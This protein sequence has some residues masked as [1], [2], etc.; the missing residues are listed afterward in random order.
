MRTPP[1]SHE[2][3]RHERTHPAPCPVHNHPMGTKPTRPG[4][5]GREQTSKGQTG[6][7]K[8]PAL[9]QGLD[10]ETRDAVRASP[11]SVVAV[12]TAVTV[13]AHFA[14]VV[15]AL[16]TGAGVLRNAEHALHAAGNAA[17]HATN[18][19]ADERADRAELRAG[20][21]A[22]FSA[23]GNALRARS[24]GH[25][26]QRERS[27]SEIGLHASVNEGARCSCHVTLP[28]V[29]YL[30]FAYRLR[31]AAP[32]LNVGSLCECSRMVTQEQHVY[33][34]R[35][36]RRRSSFAPNHGGRFNRLTIRSNEAAGRRTARRVQHAG[37]RTIRALQSGPWRPE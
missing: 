37:G 36:F 1:Q 20:V 11:P 17:D 30:G 2:R 9:R 23:A 21:E 5:K 28:T 29:L 12:M 10:Q 35:W 3:A 18:S 16:R 27:S 13:H 15:R 26:H 31:P 22:F 8:G 7:E 19:T 33:G 34:P 4:T 25:G 6:K 14:V 32:S 24:T